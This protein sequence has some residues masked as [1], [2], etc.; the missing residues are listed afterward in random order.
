MAQIT[1]LKPTTSATSADFNSAAYQQIV[2]SADALA[3]SEKVAVKVIA[4]NT[5]VVYGEGGS[6]VSLTATL[7]AAKLPGGPVY[8]FAKDATTG[9]C[10]I[11]VDVDPF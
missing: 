4:G 8:R 9:A 3:S 2:V 10:G 5:A 6:A 11:Y 1:L 7:P